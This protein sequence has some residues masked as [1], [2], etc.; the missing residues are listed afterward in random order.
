MNVGDKVEWVPSI[1][2][3]FDPVPNLGYAWDHEIKDPQTDKWSAA[4]PARV[5]NAIEIIRRDRNR[6]NE[7]RATKP[8]CAYPATVTAVD[9]DK[10]SLDIQ[11]P[12]SWVTLHYDGVAVDPSGKPGTCH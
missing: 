2:H 7:L 5:L 8:A 9:G 1:E 12:M 10:V 4:T 11:S 3:E 6:R